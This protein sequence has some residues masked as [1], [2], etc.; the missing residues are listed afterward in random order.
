MA[1]PAT[2]MDDAP[3]LVRLDASDTATPALRLG[4]Y[5]PTVGDRVAVIRQGSQLL[6]L[7]KVL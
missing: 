4:A 2:V 1:E 5:T 3:L 7:G 6:V